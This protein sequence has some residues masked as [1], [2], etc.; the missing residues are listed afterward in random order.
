MA[1]FHNLAGIERPSIDPVVKHATVAATLLHP[2]FDAAGGDS[3]RPEF[4]QAGTQG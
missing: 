2:R 4:A 3:T 1:I